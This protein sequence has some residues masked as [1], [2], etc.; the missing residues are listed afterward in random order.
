MIVKQKLTNKPYASCG[1]ANI[2]HKYLKDPMMSKNEGDQEL[3]HEISSN[4]NQQKK[5]RKESSSLCK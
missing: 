5:K 2:K 1:M 3:W 4:G